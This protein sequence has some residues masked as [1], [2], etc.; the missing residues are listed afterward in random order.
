MSVEPALPPLKK[1]GGSTIE[2][3]AQETEV[4]DA[5][6]QDVPLRRPE[7]VLQR[8]EDMR[9]QQQVAGGEFREQLREVAEDF[10][11]G[12]EIQDGFKSESRAE[13]LEEERFD[14]G[15]EFKQRVPEGEMRKGLDS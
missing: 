5:G 6:Q 13:V 2:P 15:V 3:N 11:V 1:R 4:V 14:G 7:V 9:C 10:D 12:I 8:L